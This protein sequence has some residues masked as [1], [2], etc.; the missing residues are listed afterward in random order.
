M[1][2]QGRPLAGA[3]V[4]I[5]E[6]RISVVDNAA[7]RYT[8]ALPSDEHARPNDRGARPVDRLQA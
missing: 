6:L 1:S 3:N 5:T 7:G 8:I 2:D 4:L